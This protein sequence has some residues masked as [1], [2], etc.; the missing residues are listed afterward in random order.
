[1]H[2]LNRQF[3]QV[4]HLF[5]SKGCLK[6]H[7]DLEKLIEANVR[8]GVE[9]D[10]NYSAVFYRDDSES[11]KNQKR[12]KVNQTTDNNVKQCHIPHCLLDTQFHYIISKQL[13]CPLY[14]PL[15]KLSL[16]FFN[17]VMCKLWTNQLFG[18][19]LPSPRLYLVYTNTCGKIGDLEKLWAIL[20]YCFVEYIQ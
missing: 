9:C 16:L 5:S 3:N 19:H 12:E 14:I 2:L 13:A 4:C 6:E 17:Q 10:E 7:K 1:M 18:A 20:D 11:L 15:S 8:L